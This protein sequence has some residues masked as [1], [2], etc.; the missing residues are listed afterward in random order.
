MTEQYIQVLYGFLNSSGQLLQRQDIT[1]TTRSYML[2][3]FNVPVICDAVNK[4]L[5]WD[6]NSD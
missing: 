3:L 1:L 5:Q 6:R 4:L 2:E